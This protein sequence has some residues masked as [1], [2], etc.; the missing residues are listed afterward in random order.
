MQF[1]SSKI[2]LTANRESFKLSYKLQAYI[3]FIIA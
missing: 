1:K 2:L 3:P